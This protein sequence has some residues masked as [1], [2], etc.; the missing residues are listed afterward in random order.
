MALGGSSGSALGT[1]GMKTKLSAAKR[2]MDAGCDMIIT[3]GAE[4]N[5]LYDIM[6]GLPVGTRFFAGR[7]ER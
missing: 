7:T 1:G 4:P 5:N 3:N 6:D 2:C